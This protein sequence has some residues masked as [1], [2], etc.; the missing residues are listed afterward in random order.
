MKIVSKKLRDSAKGK[1]CTFQIAKVCKNRI[2]TVVLC[3]LD[4]EDNGMGTKGN[5]LNAG[6]GCHECHQAVDGLTRPRDYTK[7]K[8]WYDR[9]A[10]VRTMTIFFSEGLISIKGGKIR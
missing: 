6:Y 9:R 7:H 3:H 2:D 1:D 10:H 5:D 8:Q 4:D